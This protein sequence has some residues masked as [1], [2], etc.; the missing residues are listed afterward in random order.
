MSLL[1]LVEPLPFTATASRGSGPDHL[2]AVDPKEAWLD[3]DTGGSVTFTLDL[4]AAV[5]I[6][7]IYVGAASL[8]A[9]STWAIAGGV[10]TADETLWQAAAPLPA[11]VWSSAARV[12]RY[13]RLTLQMPPTGAIASI[14]T[15]VVG[16]AFVASLGKEWGSGRR[17][18]D[19]GSA[20]ALPSGGFSIVEGVRKRALNWTFGDLSEA[21][22]VALERL[23]LGRGETAPV[24]VIDGETIVYGKFDR[25]RA[26]ERRNRVQTRWEVGV[27]EW[28]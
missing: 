1:K 8:P 7:T 14:G 28:L 16:R 9:G 2:A 23:A 26:F 12:A 6:D 25:W 10:A 3:A 11:G 22:A 24:L 13:V 20:T 21:E 18:I 15:L 4:A 5:S 19:T 27:E 17:P